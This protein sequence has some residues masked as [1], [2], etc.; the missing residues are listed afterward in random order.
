MKAKKAEFTFVNEHF[1]DERNAEITLLYKLLFFSYNTFIKFRPLKIK[2]HRKKQNTA[3]EK[4]CSKLGAM[5]F[6]A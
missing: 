4:F 2:H 5:L 6:Q 3:Y 1:L